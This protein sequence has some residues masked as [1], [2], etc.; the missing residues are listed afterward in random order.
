MSVSVEMPGFLRLNH[1]TLKNFIF[2]FTPILN[3]VNQY[4]FGAFLTNGV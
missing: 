2:F 1:V 3:V 4:L